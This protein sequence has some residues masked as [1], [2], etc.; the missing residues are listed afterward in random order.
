MS[1]EI[2]CH[3]AEKVNTSKAEISRCETIAIPYLRFSEYADSY[4]TG[5]AYMTVRLSKKDSVPSEFEKIFEFQTETTE[6]LD[7][8]QIYAESFDFERCIIRHALWNKEADREEYLKLL[9]RGEDHSVFGVHLSGR[10]IFCNCFEELK[11]CWEELNTRISMTECISQE[12]RPEFIEKALFVK[13]LEDCS[14]RYLWH[15]PLFVKSWENTAYRLLQE[16]N[17]LAECSDSASVEL[18]QKFDSY[19]FDFLQIRGKAG[20]ESSEAE[21]VE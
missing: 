19:V 17:R 21:M 15:F 12:N 6:K 20:I 8:W 5:P 11:K 16:M 10:I 4:V 1:Y 2:H 14:F 18:E 3:I 9:H 7:V 13:T